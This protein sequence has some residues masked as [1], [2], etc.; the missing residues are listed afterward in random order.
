MDAELLFKIA[1]MS[2]M[3]A[4]LLLVVLPKHK[5]TKLVVHSYLYPFILGIVYA[6]LIVPALFSGGEGG[7]GSVADL[8]VGFQ[9]GWVLVGAWIH[10]LIFD[11]FIGAWE[12]RDAQAKGI[13][14][15]L[16]IPCLVLTLFAGPIGLMVYLAIRYYAT[17]QATLA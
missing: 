6:F 11:L 10:Y 14:H 12:S 13:S 4:W 8:Q 7:M 16:L 9:N 17:R 1:N 3:P 15:W 5:V 2:V